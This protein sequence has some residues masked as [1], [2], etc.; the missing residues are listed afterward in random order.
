MKNCIDFQLL[1]SKNEN[2]SKSDIDTIEMTVELVAISELL[3]PKSAPVEGLK[4]IVN[5]S[6]FVIC[7]KFSCS[8]SNC[9]NY[10]W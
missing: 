5:D 4:F 8:T 3:K 7:S 1:L 6:N 10:A 2:V 9:F